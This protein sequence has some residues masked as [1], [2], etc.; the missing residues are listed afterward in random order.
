[1]KGAP[2]AGIS[3]VCGPQGAVYRVNQGRSLSRPVT[4]QF[5]L[6]SPGTERIWEIFCY[7]FRA[8]VGGGRRNP[9]PGSSLGATGWAGGLQ[10]AGREAG[11]ASCPSPS[12]LSGLGSHLATL[13]PSRCPEPPLSSL[14]PAC[15]FRL[16]GLLYTCVFP[17]PRPRRQR[18]RPVGPIPL[19]LGD[20]AVQGGQPRSLSKPTSCPASHPAAPLPPGQTAEG[21]RLRTSFLYLPPPAEP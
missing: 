19:A 20:V 13:G 18:L 9:A 4:P 3:R 15:Q 14:H 21:P 17:A 1:M 10:G 12:A 6:G 8:F 5:A 2:E 7:L 11:P 16:P